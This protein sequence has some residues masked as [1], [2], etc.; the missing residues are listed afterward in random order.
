MA[1]LLLGGVG[2][3][4]LLLFF[5]LFLFM[6]DLTRSWNKLSLDEREGSR[7]ILKNQLWSSEFIIVAKF[8]TK[9]VLNMEAVARMFRQLCVDTRF[10]THDLIKEDDWNDYLCTQ[11]S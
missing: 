6:E 1:L 5:C 2:N 8:L 11:N 7:F 3:S 9:R 4:F 10:Y